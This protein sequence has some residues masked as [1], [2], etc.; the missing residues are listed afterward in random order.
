[1][2]EVVHEC[3]VVDAL[4]RLPA[5]VGHA[6]AGPMDEETVSAFK[7]SLREYAVWIRIAVT[8]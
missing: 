3:W 1:M 7:P 5:R 8:D 6:L 4:R 2:L